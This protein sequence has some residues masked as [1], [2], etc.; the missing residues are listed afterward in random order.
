MT[1]SI[2][3]CVEVLEDMC[4]VDLTEREFEALSL[5]IKILSRLNEEFIGYLLWKQKY[6]QSKTTY[7]EFKKALTYKAT[8][9]NPLEYLGQC[10]MKEYC[11]KAQ[12]LINSLVKEEE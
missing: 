7:Q 1:M 5:A 10:E 9:I 4:N 3:E 12:S 2:E 11:N 6:L 8:E